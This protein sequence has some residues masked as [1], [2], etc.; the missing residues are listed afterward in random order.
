M[1]SFSANA[2]SRNLAR[3]PRTP[4]DLIVI[5]G[6]ITGAGILRDAVLR[7]MRTLLLEK[8]DFA[9]GTSSKSSKLVHGGLRYLKEY[10]FGLTRESCLERNLLIRQNPH[11]VKPIPFVYP[12]YRTDKE[13]PAMV[14]AGMWLYEALGGFRNYQRHRM[15]SV[16]ETLEEIPDLNPEGLRGAAYYYDAAV[17]DARLTLE[18]IKAGVRQGGVALNYAAAIGFL[19]EKGRICGVVVRDMRTWETFEARASCVVNATGVWVNDVRSLEAPAEKTLSP[20]KGVHIVVPS[21]RIRQHATLAFRNPVDER[22]LFSIPWGDVTLIGTTDTF[23]QG[24]PEGVHTDWDDVDYLLEAANQAF[25]ASKLSRSDVISVFAGLR[26]L[27]APREE[28]DA[29]AISREHEIFEDPSGLISI[30]GGKLTTYRLMARELV[31]QVLAHLPPARRHR[32]G[33]C[34]T[35]RSLARSVLDVETEVER[36]VDAGQSETVARHLVSTYG[37]DATRVLDLCRTVPGGLDPLDEGAPF[38]QG[39][40]VHAVRHECALTI[41]DVLTRR[42][43]LAIWR[44]G[45]GLPAAETVSRLMGSE[46]G[47]SEEERAAEVERYQETVDKFYRPVGAAGA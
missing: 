38:L 18:N 5:G 16:E 39:E 7:G 27:I 11:L 34:L 24:D 37:S 25:P 15:L 1:I 29:G 2:R 13:G 33:P 47:W 46:L 9:S 20:T 41:A 43:R 28:A 40:V 19:R 23:F 6:G 8:G 10:D 30:A 14:K 4:F 36:L 45:Q 3:L 17:D 42:L 26:P 31:D 44:P 12:I 22:Q 21:S 35:E 32:I